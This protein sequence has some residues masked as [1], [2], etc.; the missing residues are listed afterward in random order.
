MAYHFL[1]F[2]SF[3]WC[4]WLCERI[5]LQ[6]ICPKVLFCAKRD[7]ILRKERR[8]RVKFVAPPKE[9]QLS[10]SNVQFLT[11]YDVTNRKQQMDL[12]YSVVWKGHKESQ[13]YV[14]GDYY[15]MLHKYLMHIVWH[16]ASIDFLL[17]RL[18]KTSFKTRNK[19]D[20]LSID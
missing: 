11:N 13:N 8:E 3:F 17:K 6:C 12:T 16:L 15:C 1:Y 9:M 2:R 19:T 10:F 18:I 7:V 20:C 4:D 14:N 5:D